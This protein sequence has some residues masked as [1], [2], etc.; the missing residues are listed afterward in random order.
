MSLIAKAI[1][2]NNQKF[3]EEKAR[4]RCGKISGAIGIALNTLLAA[5]KMIVGGLFGVISVFADGLNNLTDCGGNVVS[6][7]GFKMSG[8][9]ADKEH[10]FGHQRA[11]SIAALMIAFI[12]LM[13]AAE[14]AIQSVEKIISPEKSDFSI[15][16]I[17]VLSVSIAVKVWM[18]LFNRY[19]SKAI[20]SEALRATATDSISDSV[21]TLAVLVSVIISRFTG[22]E[23]DGY[24]GVAVALFIAFAGLSILKDTVSGLIGKAPDK[25]V[26][27][28]V[29]TRILSFPD[30]HGL[31]DLTVHNYGQNKLYAT[32][33]VEVDANMP[34]MAAHDLADNIERNF[35]DHTDIILT[36]HIDPLVLDDPKINKYRET[37]EKIIS[38]ISTDMKMHDFRVVGG[39]SHS[40]LVFDVAVP[41]DEKLSNFEITEKI[42]DRVS[43]L[44]ENLDVVATIE[45]QN[46][47]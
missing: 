44:G 5:G 14:L 40:N 13:V 29:K 42:K 16:L 12:V 9:P 41:F 33:H 18:F 37:V 6:L 10:P 27:E 21:A 47:D 17:I 39:I 45:R 32:A 35:A 26:I 38:E 20:S 19:L 43:L 30:V 24:M 7:I 4:E 28:E 15:L 11:E 46:I 23:L 1:L 31:H 25:E 3:S 34:I 8:K 22:I 2:K 36:V